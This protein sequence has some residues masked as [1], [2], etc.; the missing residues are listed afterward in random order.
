LKGGRNL[1]KNL[2]EKKSFSGEAVKVVGAEYE[3][4]MPEQPHCWRGK[5]PGRE[6]MLKY[7]RSGERY[8]FS[9][10]WYGSEKRKNPA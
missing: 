10:E 1:A 2:E 3:P 8:W 4:G 9:K 6:E 5:I 7:L